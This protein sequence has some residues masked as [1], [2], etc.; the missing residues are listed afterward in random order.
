MAWTGSELRAERER[1]GMTQ[2]AVAARLSVTPARVAFIENSIHVT[3]RAAGSY[4]AALEPM[5]PLQRLARA[6]EE[7]TRATEAMG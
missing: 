2:R 1:Q 3:D 4:L 5:A 6:T 7:L